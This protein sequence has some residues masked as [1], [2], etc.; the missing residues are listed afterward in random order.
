[1]SIFV[2]ITAD[3]TIIQGDDSLKKWLASMMILLLLIPQGF[4]YAETTKDI[5]VSFN[6]M[7]IK[8]NGQ[9][10]R[11]NNI[12]Y[13]GT[14]Y[15][16]IRNIAEIMHDFPVTFY[17]NEKIVNIG[18]VGAGMDEPGIASEQ[19]DD[20]SE[21]VVEE[22]RDA[23]ISAVFDAITIMVHLEKVDSSNILYNGRTYVPLRALSN[24][25]D[26]DVYY[27][28]PTTTAY[29]GTIPE[30]ELAATPEP[31][32]EPTP[33]PAT[34]GM[35][36]V[37]AEGDLAGWMLLKGHDYENSVQ[38][39]YQLNG[40]ITASMVKDIRKVNMNEIIHWVDDNGVKRSN[41]RRDLHVLFGTFSEYTSEWFYEKFGDVYLDYFG[42]SSI[43]AD[44]LI[45]QYLKETGQIKSASSTLPQPSAPVA[46]TPPTSRY[47]QYEDGTVVFYAYDKYHAYQG[48]YI[49]RDDPN[50]SGFLHDGQPEP[51]K[52]SDKWMP[53]SILLQIY[54][55]KFHYESNNL[56]VKNAKEEILRLP[57]PA[58]WKRID[59][60]EETAKNIRIQKFH[61]GTDKQITETWIDEDALE[62]KSGIDVVDSMD[63][64]TEI[65][66]RTTEGSLTKELYTFEV[67]FSWYKN[68]DGEELIIDGFHVKKKDGKLMFLVEDLLRL[69]ILTISEESEDF[70]I[71]LHVDD[72]RKAGVIK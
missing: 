24:I 17:P 38:I 72:L 57:L 35:Y 37:A 33:A 19:S 13:D 7:N 42:T 52:L 2:K 65:Q 29:I 1:L 6:K 66:F 41:T 50:Y 10:V 71:Y 70:S 51:P 14:T 27:H 3:S 4:I 5:Q 62:Q 28:E 22:A 69:K 9:S 8:V 23:T 40:S 46:T 60:T 16:P 47:S 32:P 55:A 59:V 36:S 11:I 63:D 30:G 18:F 67:P 44:K 20:T 64:M 34:S 54:D 25:V 68:R 39:Y 43:D 26:L 61:T 49:D 12:L 15:V 45:Q 53:L 21:D 31:E 48:E 58:N 56:V